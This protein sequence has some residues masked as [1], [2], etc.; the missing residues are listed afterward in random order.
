MTLTL[1]FEGL[2]IKKLYI[3]NGIVRWHGMKKMWMDSMLDPFALD[4]HGEILKNCIPRMGWLI[5]MERKG[6]EFERKLGLLCDFE[7]WPHPWPSSYIFLV[8]YQIGISQK[9]EVRLIR[10]ETDWVGYNVGPTMQP[11]TLTS[12]M[13][14]YWMFGFSRTTF[15]NSCISL[16]DGP[17]IWVIRKMN[18]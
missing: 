5:D 11:W 12:T 13:T 18:R 17:I 15:K 16:M 3:M 6:Y 1:N 10:N 2:M 8:S 7:L 9:W 4:F 14:W